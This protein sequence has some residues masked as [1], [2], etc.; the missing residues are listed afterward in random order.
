MTNRSGS[1]HLHGAGHNVA[2]A[3]AICILSSGLFIT[4]QDHKAT[5]ISF[6]APG[7]GTAGTLPQAITPAGAITGFYF[8]ANFTDHG[9]LRAPDGSFTTFDPA[10]SLGTAP[11]SINPA[12]AI[13][14]SYIDASNVNHGFL[15]EGE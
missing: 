3:L 6:D 13:A 11:F 8:D 12:G 14:G 1:H 15:L 4:A 10:G 5:I 2:P 9:F 7:A